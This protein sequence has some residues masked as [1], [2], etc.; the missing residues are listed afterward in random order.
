M[1]Q[2]AGT[3]VSPEAE[4]KTNGSTATFSIILFGLVL[5]LPGVYIGLFGWFYF[6]IPAMV[7]FY[8]YRWRHGLSFVIGGLLLAAAGSLFLS[9]LEVALFGATLIPAGYSLAQSGF[10][11]ES[12]TRS[13]FKG[14]VVLLCCWLLFLSLETLLSGVNPIAEFISTLDQDIARTLEYYR[15]SSAVAPETLAILEESFFQIKTVLPK[16]MVSLMISLALII[17]WSTMIIGN[18]IVLKFTGYRPWPDHQRW[19]LPERLI[20]LFIG[21]ALITLL[22][23]APIRIIGSNLLIC[24]SLIYLFQGFSV[25]SFFLHKWQVPKFLRYVLYA[26]MLFQSFGTLLLLIAGVSEV[27]FDLRRLKKIPKDLQNNSDK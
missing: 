6:M 20:W 26:M 3:I 18:R 5:L 16:V 1:N 13:G 27:W 12:P 9:S 24:L 4:G 7:L 17:I 14:S 15:Q 2:T 8:L 10:G 19:A 25:L 23:F 22:P 11:N 21:A